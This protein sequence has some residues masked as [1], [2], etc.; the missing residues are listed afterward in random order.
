MVITLR[1]PATVRDQLAER[2]ARI[3]VS[4]NALVATIVDEALR[5]DDRR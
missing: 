2:A 1:V 4:V 5:K 3:G